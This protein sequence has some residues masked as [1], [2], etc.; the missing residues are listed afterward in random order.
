MS[1]FGVGG[2]RGVGGA[3]EAEDADGNHVFSH[4]ET[5]NPLN[6]LPYFLMWTLEMVLLI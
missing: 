5:K 4:L 3:N 6:F 1:H 2:A